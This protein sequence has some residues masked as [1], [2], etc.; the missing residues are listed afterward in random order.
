MTLYQLQTYFIDCKGYS[1]ED[2][3]GISQSELWNNLTEEEQSQAQQ[4]IGE[5]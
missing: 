3:Q 2:V 5:K 4:F 1:E